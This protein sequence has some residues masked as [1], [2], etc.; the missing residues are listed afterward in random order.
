M[1][2]KISNWL[3]SLFYKEKPRSRYTIGR[4]R[5]KLLAE[6]DQTVDLDDYQRVY[7]K[8]KYSLISEYGLDQL[9]YESAVKIKEP[10][11]IIYMEGLDR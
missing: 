10:V 7:H 1:I 11:V 8:Y 2:A 3:K 5:V 4:R 9:I 6:Y